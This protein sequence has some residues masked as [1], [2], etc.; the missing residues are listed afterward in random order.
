MT[1]EFFKKVKSFIYKIYIQKILNK[2]WKHKK[3][4]KNLRFL[5]QICKEKR[6]QKT[7]KTLPDGPRPN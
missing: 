4:Q 2:F 6:K 3:K 7:E 1:F 5:K